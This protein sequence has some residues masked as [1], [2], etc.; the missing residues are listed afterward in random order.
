VT[1]T[2]LCAEPYKQPLIPSAIIYHLPTCTEPC[3][4]LLIPPVCQVRTQQH[5]TYIWYGSL[6]SGLL[7]LQV[8]CGKYHTICVTASSQVYAWGANSSGQLGLGDKRDRLAPTVVDAL[9]AL[10]VVQ[11]AA[12]DLHSVALTTNGHLFTWGS[13][14]VGQLGLPHD[15]DH[16][17][18]SSSS[19]KAEGRR[20]RYAPP[21]AAPGLAAATLPCS[22]SLTTGY[23][24]L[25][26]LHGNPL[27][28]AMQQ[29]RCS[30]HLGSGGTPA[31]MAAM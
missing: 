21:V 1:H 22:S 7:F 18:Q 14:S 10:P 29:Q 20:S 31:L 2:K 13:N 6:W 23:Q 17:A 24:P 12:G 19:S 16:A 9:W 25:A 26:N 30:F 3:R 4:L 15:A 8:V 28:H 5:R 11:L 27:Q